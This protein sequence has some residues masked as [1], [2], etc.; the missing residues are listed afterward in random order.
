MASGRRPAVGALAEP[1]RSSR[2][3]DARSRVSGGDG[4]LLTAQEVAAMLG[5]SHEYVW[6]LS[7]E[8]RIPTITLGRARRYRRASILAWLE[9]IESP[10]SRT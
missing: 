7:R 8:G 3:N 5:V 2:R 4:K 6:Q 9:Q 1:T 10:G